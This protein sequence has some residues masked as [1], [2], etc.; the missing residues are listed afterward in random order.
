[1]EDRAESRSSGSGDRLILMPQPGR[2]VERNGPDVARWAPSIGVHRGMQGHARNFW[3]KNRQREQWR[4]KVETGVTTKEGQDKEP[5]D[6]MEAA[7]RNAFILARAD[8]LPA[9]KQ[10]PSSRA[11]RRGLPPRLDGVGLRDLALACGPKGCTTARDCRSGSA[12]DRPFPVTS[13]RSRQAAAR[14]PSLLDR[15]PTAAVGRVVGSC[16]CRR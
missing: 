7:R 16:S 11:D 15:S 1:M 4:D 12:S 2:K 13:C 14:L 8:N 10:S 9:Q 3:L 5:I 6:T